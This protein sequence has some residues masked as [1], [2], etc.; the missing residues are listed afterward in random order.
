MREAMIPEQVQKSWKHLRKLE[1]GGEH[2]V[3]SLHQRAEAAVR[4][5]GI[6]SQWRF[7]G[8]Q[9]GLPDSQS[10]TVTW[11]ME[12]GWS[13]FPVHTS[14]STGSEDNLYQRCWESLPQWQRT[15][16]KSKHLS[17]RQNPIEACKPVG[18]SGIVSLLTLLEWRSSR[19]KCAFSCR[20][21]YATAYTICP[22]KF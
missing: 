18:R 17:K 3:Y 19:A 8:S 2:M 11:G 13:K 7:R 15:F 6:F 20:K 12:G 9:A 22:C 21:C 4:T 14:R 5:T 1:L 10:M 16:S